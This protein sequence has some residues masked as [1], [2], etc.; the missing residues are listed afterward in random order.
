VLP[1]ESGDF[2]FRPRMAGDTVLP[3]GESLREDFELVESDIDK[4]HYGAQFL[5]SIAHVSGD[6]DLIEETVTL[7]AHLATGG[8]WENSCMRVL[9][10]LNSRLAA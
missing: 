6:N 10:M 3:D 1:D 4:I 5:N 7:N 8:G 9:D 2:A